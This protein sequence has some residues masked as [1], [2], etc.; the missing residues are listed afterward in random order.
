MEFGEQP[1]KSLLRLDVNVGAAKE[2]VELFAK[3]RL[4]AFDR[5]TGDVRHTVARGLTEILSAEMS[6]FLGRPEQAENKRNGTRVREYYLKG[7][8]CLRIEVPRDRH[9]KFES[10]IVPTHERM[11]PCLH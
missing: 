11:D 5:L 7:L 10:V 3:D 6:L 2:L 1:T 9:G 8:G 4:A